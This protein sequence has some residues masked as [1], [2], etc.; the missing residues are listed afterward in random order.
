MEFPL[1]RAEASVLEILPEA[2]STNDELVRRAT[3]NESSNWPDL[4]VLATPEPDQ[5]PRQAGSQLGLAG[6]Q[7]PGDLGA[8]SPAH[9]DR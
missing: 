5:G 3:G 9:S 1:S 8:A 6:R 4:S 7:I 2:G